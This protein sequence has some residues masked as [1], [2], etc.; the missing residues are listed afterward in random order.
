MNLAVYVPDHAEG[1]RL[2]VV[3]WLSGLTCTEQNSITKAGAQLCVSKRRAIVVSADSRARN[4]ASAGPGRLP[5][6]IPPRSTSSVRKLRP[7]GCRALAQPT[8]P[9]TITSNSV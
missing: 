8:A 1:E 6:P 9:M 5:A 2:P 4:R 7:A 3:Y